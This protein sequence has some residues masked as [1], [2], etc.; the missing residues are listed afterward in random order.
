MNVTRIEFL[1]DVFVQGEE[2][3]VQSQSI[4]LQA[5]NVEFN[6]QDSVSLSV[7]NSKEGLEGPFNISRGV[8]IPEGMYSFD[9]M[10]LSIRSGDQRAIGGGFFIND[11]E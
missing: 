11:G 9:S 3:D 2:L 1:D 4:N 5:L 6:S 10:N 8:V 7:S